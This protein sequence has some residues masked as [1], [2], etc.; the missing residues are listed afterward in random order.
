MPAV[1]KPTRNGGLLVFLAGFDG[2]FAPETAP[3]RCDPKLRPVSFGSVFYTLQGESNHPEVF[4][5][6]FQPIGQEPDAASY[7]DEQPPE[8]PRR[9]GFPFHRALAAFAAI[10]EA[11]WSDKWGFRRS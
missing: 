2:T 4:T 1:P 5:D 8:V 6:F 9:H 10:C 3:A 7:Q 11:R